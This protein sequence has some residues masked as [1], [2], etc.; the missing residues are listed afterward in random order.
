MGICARNKKNLHVSKGKF[1]NRRRRPKS[2]TTEERKENVSP[3]S[4]TSPLEGSRI[5]NLEQLASFVTNIGSHSKSCPMG[6][7]TLIGETY[8]NGMASVLSAKCSSCRMEIAFQHH[9]RLREWEVGSVGRV[10]WQRCGGRCL[11]MVAMHT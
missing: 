9:T 2:R 6:N 10:M 11:L 8:H 7:V 5:I 3:G 1:I 4:S